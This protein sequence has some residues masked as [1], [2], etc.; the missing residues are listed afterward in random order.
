MSMAEVIQFGILLNVTAGL[1]ALGFAWIDD[2][3]GAKRT[4]LIALVGLF[5]CG[6]AAVVASSTLVFWLAG[7]LLGIFVGPTQAASRSLMARMAP[8]EVRT[9]MF[10][11][12]ALTGKITAYIGPFLLGTVT[13]WSG[14]QRFGIATILV[15]FVIGGLLLLPLKEPKA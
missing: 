4:I 9:E 2:R 15:F 13:F 8:A 6:T 3:I 12:Y 7:G 1:G 10:G 14:S 5:A 11:L